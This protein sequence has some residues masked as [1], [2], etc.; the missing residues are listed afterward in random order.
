V[1]KLSWKWRSGHP[2]KGGSVQEHHFWE[3]VAPSVISHPQEVRQVT[4]KPWVARSGTSRSSPSRRAAPA[5]P[6]RLWP[7]PWPAH[8]ATPALGPR[9]AKM[10]CRALS[11]APPPTRGYSSGCR[12][13]ARW[14]RPPPRLD[15][16]AGLGCPCQCENKSATSTH[17]KR[18]LRANVPCFIYS[19]RQ[20]G[21]RPRSDAIPRVP[22]QIWDGL[23]H[24]APSD[25][26]NSSRLCSDAE[27]TPG[28]RRGERCSA[29][30]WSNATYEPL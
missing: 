23:A 19:V 30:P 12:R 21:G 17:R 18:T 27:R 2:P 24:G 13:T 11:R 8:N 28:H 5:P 15:R 6:L 10:G 4:L 16:H 20:D 25:P 14:R 3:V 22:E 29:P 1:M 26:Q 7:A 9:G